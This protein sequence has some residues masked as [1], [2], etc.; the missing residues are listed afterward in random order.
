[1]HSSRRGFTLV[2]LL[3]VITII[4]MLIALLLPA[5][6]GA[7]EAAR[8]AQCSNNLK[9]IGLA[10][11]GY[12]QS[13][14]MLPAGQYQYDCSGNTTYGGSVFIRLLPYVEQQP[15]Y[16]IYDLSST[17]DTQKYP[18]TSKYLGSTVLPVYICPSDQPSSPF[19][20]GRVM[21]KANYA[22][23]AGPCPV[24]SKPG[25]T[26]DLATSFNMYAS[27]SDSKMP[28]P[29]TRYC[30]RQCR[31]T[32][33]TDGLSNTIFFGEVRPAWDGD[34]GGGWHGSCSGNGYTKTTVP[35]NYYSGDTSYTGSNGCS[36]IGSWTTAFGFKSGHPGG[37]HFVLGDGTV[38]FLSETV[39]FQT[40]QYLGNK[41]DGK[42]FAMPW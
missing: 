24:G 16:D 37:A 12:E 41:A 15:L 27:G 40:Y 31:L 4:G 13:H 38:H 11:M 25:A 28:G 22:A 6:Q 2:E 10:V 21:A 14:E 30:G 8:R 42:G 33:I 1:M 29:F 9:Q 18:G 32:E 36:W 17:V 23:S 39:D 20:L 35:I 3:V 19:V 26:C 5:V 7:R 34:T